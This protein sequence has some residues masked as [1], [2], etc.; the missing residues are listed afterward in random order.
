[1]KCLLTKNHQNKS[2]C[3]ELTCLKVYFSRIINFK[4]SSSQNGTVEGIK[5]NFD[6]LKVRLANP[7]VSNE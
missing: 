1:M 2:M 4:P 6:P 5:I 7:L 3:K